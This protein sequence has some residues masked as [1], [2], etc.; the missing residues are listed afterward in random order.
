MKAYRSGVVVK[1]GALKVPVNIYSALDSTKAAETR[2]N[3]VCNR[4]HTP[5][6]TKNPYVCETC[7]H[8]GPSTDFVRGKDTENG[9][10]V[11]D[12]TTVETAIDPMMK[13]EIVLTA[14]PLVEVLHSTVP[15][16]KTYSLGPANA[17]K[18][19]GSSQDEL[20]EGYALL[21]T[22][23]AEHPDHALIGTF[24]FTSRAAMFR[25]CMVGD[26]I[27]MTQLA[28]PEEL[29]ET[30]DVPAPLTDEADK[31]LVAGL[32][33]K[34]VQSFDPAD[35]KDVNAEARANAIEAAMNGTTPVSVTPTS[36]N[37]PVTSL[38]DR[39]REELA[40]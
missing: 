34:H 16:G 26:V 37:A 23:V 32:L 27:S 1:L 25:L 30:P 10:V 15:S 11:V 19:K 38:R 21:Q 9:V 39:L 6:L 5:T 3:V 40:A 36:N 33:T 17:K 31:S 12:T 2:L 18:I 4:D 20:D 28:W 8:Q 35:Y 7:N 13:E 22:L 24:A 29:K 14:H